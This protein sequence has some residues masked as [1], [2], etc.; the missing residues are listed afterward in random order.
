MSILT[1]FI[2]QCDP[3]ERYLRDENSPYVS[4]DSGD[5]AHFLD[6][7]SAYA[8]A[9]RRG[10]SAYPLICPECA[11]EWKAKVL[12]EPQDGRPVRSPEEGPE[13]A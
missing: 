5:A 4:A 13:R 12:D 1:R 10:W 2:V 11:A 7:S 3:C 9:V 8:E 6:F